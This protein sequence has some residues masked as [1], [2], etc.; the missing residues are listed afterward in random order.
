MQFIKHFDPDL[1]LNRK[2]GLFR[3]R[4]FVKCDKR[5]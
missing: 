1:A 3:N 5:F 2:T 4:F